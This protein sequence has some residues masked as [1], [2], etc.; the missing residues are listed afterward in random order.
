MMKHFIDTL[1]KIDKTVMIEDHHNLGS[2]YGYI[3][4]AL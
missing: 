1:M 3:S 4:A 2:F